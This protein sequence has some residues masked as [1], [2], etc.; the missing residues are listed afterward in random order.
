[1][2]GARTRTIVLWEEEIQVYKTSERKPRRRVSSTLLRLVT[3]IVYGFVVVLRF[4]ILLI[5]TGKLCAVSGW[6]LFL[7]S[8]MRK[9]SVELHA[10]RC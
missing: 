1:M 3:E 6:N 10:G 8:M 5:D 2:K 9:H 4:K 7:G